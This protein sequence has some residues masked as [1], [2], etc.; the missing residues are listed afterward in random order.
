MCQ[1]SAVI[2]VQEAGMRPVACTN[3]V[4]HTTELSHAGLRNENNEFR[5]PPQDVCLCVCTDKAK[6]FW[7]RGL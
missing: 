7:R 5:Y 6:A 4:F 3:P 1:E 2:D